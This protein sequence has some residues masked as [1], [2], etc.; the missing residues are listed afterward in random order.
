MN[1]V[2]IVGLKYGNIVVRM[3]VCWLLRKYRFTTTLS[4]EDLQYRMSITLKIDSGHMVSIHRR[5]EY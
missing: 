2:H 4:L 1:F 5:N 3:F